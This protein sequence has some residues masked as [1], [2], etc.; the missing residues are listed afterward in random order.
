MTKK[1]RNYQIMLKECIHE[2]ILTQF[3]FCL[4]MT[5]ILKEVDEDIAKLNQYI[6]NILFQVMEC[7]CFVE[8]LEVVR[9]IIL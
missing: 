4:I 7:I 1:A 2:D 6:N 8:D 5:K 3:Y 9:H